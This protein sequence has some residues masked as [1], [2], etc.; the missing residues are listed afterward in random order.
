MFKRTRTKSAYAKAYIEESVSDSESELSDRESE[1]E[2]SA[3]LSV[4]RECDEY[5]KAVAS[6]AKVRSTVLSA[7]Q[8]GGDDRKWLQDSGCS[9]NMSPHR[10]LFLEFNPKIKGRVEIADGVCLKIEG[11]G[12]VNMK[13]AEKCGGWSL[14]LKRVLYVPELEDNLMSMRQLDKKGFEVKIKRGKLTAQDDKG[15]L[16]NQWEIIWWTLWMKIMSM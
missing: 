6:K 16:R 11:A 5:V 1:C 12:M 4:K 13:L 14:K 9:D 15:D 3:E 7:M 2:S 8:K 10:E